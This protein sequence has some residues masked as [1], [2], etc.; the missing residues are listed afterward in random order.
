MIIMSIVCRH[1][2]KVKAASFHLLEYCRQIKQR[3]I[4]AVITQNK[5]VILPYFVP[6]QTVY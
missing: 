2:P 1:G 3:T 5:L 6:A 4:Y